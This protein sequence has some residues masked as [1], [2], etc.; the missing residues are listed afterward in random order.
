MVD[1]WDGLRDPEWFVTLLNERDE[2]L[3]LLEGVRGGEVQVAALERLGGSATLQLTRT[4]QVIDWMKHRV[5]IEYELEEGGA[6]IPWGVWVLS[7]PK[8]THDMIDFWEVALLPKMVVIDEDTVADTFSL[9]QGSVVTSIV[10]SLILST[11]ETRIALTPSA[12][13]TTSAL[14]WEAGTSKLTI[15]N[16][17]LTAIDYS[18]LWCD[19]SGQFRVEPY[20]S[21][22]DRVVRRTFRADDWSLVRPGWS[23][24][25]DLTGIPNRVVVFCE[26]TDTDPAI[27]GVDQNTDP[28]SP[29]SIPS[30]GRVITRRIEVTDVASQAE[31]DALATRYLFSSMNPV[32]SLGV[33]T[34]IVPLE[35]NDRVAFIDGNPEVTRDATV[36]RMRV[37][38]TFDS[39]CEH[40]WREI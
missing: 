4:N 23:R 39:L 35:R 2:A 7:S 14:V 18:A 38:L 32:A 36:L 22:R 33:T 11:G 5:Q 30:R 8:L 24:E 15:I 1:V 26:G 10:E 6:R 20:I 16:D 9:D 17:L 31:A 12:R 21:P 34:A 28:A 3:G 40:E 37:Q 27:S 19:G 13:T 25:Q 29:F